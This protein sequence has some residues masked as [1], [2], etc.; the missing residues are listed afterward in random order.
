M[1]SSVQLVAAGAIVGALVGAAIGEMGAEAEALCGAAYGERS[2]ERVNTRNG[3][4]LTS[5]GARASS[6]ARRGSPSPISQ[7]HG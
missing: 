4:R 5:S 2:P 3:Y 6:G 7:P 1:R